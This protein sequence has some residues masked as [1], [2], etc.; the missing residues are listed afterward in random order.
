MENVCRVWKNYTVKKVTNDFENM[1]FNTAISQMM[2]F[3]NSVS[4]EDVLPKEYAEGFLKLLNPI[5]PHITEEL[6]NMLG[7]DNTISYE[8]WP[9][10]DESKTIDDEIELPVQVNGKLKATV[11]ITLDE[12]ETSIKE[13]VHSALEG[14]T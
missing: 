8:P 9:T 10:Y 3:V 6:W 7:H 4:K 13:K 11:M 1:Y 12:N 5:A 14:K 2:I